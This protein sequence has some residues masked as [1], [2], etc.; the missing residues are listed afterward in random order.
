MSLKQCRDS[1]LFWRLL[2]ERDALLAV[3]NMLGGNVS[4]VQRHTVMLKYQAGDSCED[5]LLA[6]M[7]TRS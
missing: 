1:S 4:V 2:I 6:A 5:L 7:A 3:S